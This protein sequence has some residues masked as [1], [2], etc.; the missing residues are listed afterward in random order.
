MIKKSL[1]ALIVLF[2]L[3]SCHKDKP[4][5]IVAK[6][7]YP[8]PGDTFFPEGIAFNSKT[9]NFYTG[10][11]ANGDIVQVNVETGA[12]K[13]LALGKSQNRNAAT[14]MKID[15]M[16]RLW[17]SGGG[18]NKIQVLDLDGNLIKSWD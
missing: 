18:D 12:T 9:G 11:V 8:L 4:D 2:F 17:V 16:N 6:E 1:S 14:G 15:R 13:I 5:V 3:A 7:S 10:S